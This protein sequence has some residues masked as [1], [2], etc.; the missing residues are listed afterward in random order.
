MRRGVPGIVI[1][2]V[3]LFNSAPVMGAQT[4]WTVYQTLDLENVP[5]DM[6]VEPKN[7][8]VYILDDQGEIAI[9][10]FNGRL[11]GKI[12]V[13]PDVLQI[14]AGPTE[15]MLF[16]LRQKSKTVESIL[17]TLT[18]Q[19]DIQGS[20]F[21]GAADAP[22]TLAVFSDFQCPYCARLVPVLDQVLERYPGKVK[23]VFKHFPLRSHPFA[24]KAARASMAAF[25]MGKFWAFH[26]LLFKNYNQISDQKIE[27]VRAKLDLDAGKF[28]REMS[29]DRTRARISAD[30]RNG[31]EA[32]VRGTPTVFV[33]GKELR[34]KSL[35][36]FQRA[37]DDALEK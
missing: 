7:Q 17:I 26:D 13:G 33:N 18:E 6:L 4:D 10:T 1:L 29:A 30:I 24:D 20:P 28:A 14:K 37:I 8:R 5:V 36:G 3:F 22:V 15:N 31:S 23:V 25:H 32:G 12:T 21:K 27:E 19:I 35:A 11:K 2:L 34:N 9:Y 16:L